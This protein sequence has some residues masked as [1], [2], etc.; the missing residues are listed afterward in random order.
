MGDVEFQGPHSTIYW[1]EEKH[2][3]LQSLE[4]AVTRD[5]LKQGYN[6]NCL[7]W[8]TGCAICEKEMWKEYLRNDGIPHPMGGRMGIWTVRGG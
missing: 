5:M 4:E 1:E 8:R 7:A 3:E 2:R 6:T